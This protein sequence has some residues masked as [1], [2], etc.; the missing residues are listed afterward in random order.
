MSTES[1]FGQAVSPNPAQVFDWLDDTARRMTRA[2]LARH[3]HVRPTDAGLVNL[4][5]NDYASLATHPRV[6]D[7]LSAAAT[8]W[9]GGATAARLVTGTVEV[10][11]QLERELAAFCGTEAALV[12][13]SGYLANLGTLTALSRPHSLLVADSYVHASLVDGCR[14]SGAQTLSAAH[15]DVNAVDDL[16][17]QRPERRVLVV[18]ESVFS[19][20]GDAAPLTDL[21]ETCRRHGAPLVVDD[22][23][24][25]GVI[26]VGGRGAAEAASL[27]G[28]PDVVLTGTLGKS[29]GA[30]GGFVAGPRRVVDHIMNMARPFLFDTG[31]SPVSAAGALASLRVLREESWRPERARTNA[32]RIATALAE[33]GLPTAH[34]AAA[35]VSVRAPSA[36]AAVAWAAGCRT[37]GVLVGCFRP[38]SV[39][40]RFS[41]LR[42]SVRA[43]LDDDAV[44]RAT[45]VIAANS[46]W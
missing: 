5:S 34:P 26:G 2:G 17:G 30:Q 23:H 1:D 18:T 27:A 22:A 24:G 25:F 37:Q 42:L 31:L 10:H 7:A 32:L 6:V 33:H 38:P 35:V 9:G 39:P 13:S 29:L 16:L 11:V 20:D 4:S 19:V 28:Q 8:E 15:N 40:D 21:L 14:L 36:S 43:G 12:F 3:L 44:E 41:R 46:P 45:A